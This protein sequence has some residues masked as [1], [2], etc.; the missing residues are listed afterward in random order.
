MFRQIASAFD[1]FF[2]KRESFW[3]RCLRAAPEGLEKSAGAGARHERN[4]R[5]SSHT[6]FL[7]PGGAGEARFAGGATRGCGTFSRPS[8]ME[9]RVRTCGT[10]RSTGESIKLFRGCL[11]IFPQA[12]A[13]RQQPRRTR[14]ADDEDTREDLPPAISAPVAAPSAATPIPA[15]SATSAASSP[16]CASNRGTSWSRFE[17]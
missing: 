10:P 17:T 11:S 12:S 16:R 9:G 6:P 14:S 1:R 8:G 5:V 13:F 7:R 15:P 2:G 4:H 3:R